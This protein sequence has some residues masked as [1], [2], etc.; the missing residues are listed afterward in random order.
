[1]LTD[2]PDAARQLPDAVAE[3]KKVG[4]PFVAKDLG[5]P[6]V[7]DSENA[8]P[9][10]NKFR[11]L[12]EEIRKSAQIQGDLDKAAA[13]VASATMPSERADAIKAATELLGQSEERLATLEAAASKPQVDFRRDWDLGPDLLFPEFAS[14]KAGIKLLSARAIVRAATDDALGAVQDLGRISAITRF[15]GQDP[16]IISLLV[17]IACE[18]IR[19]R[20]IERIT[21]LWSDSPSRLA[22]LQQAL[23]QE[24][25]PDFLY[26]MR[27]EVY[28]GIAVCRNL[29]KYGGADRFLKGVSSASMGNEEA[30]PKLDAKT[31][32]RDG[33]PE[34]E[35]SRAFMARHLQAWAGVWPDLTANRADPAKMGKRLDEMARKIEANKGASY[36]LSAVLY[37]VFTQAGLA[38]SR[39][40]A[41][42]DATASM[43]DVVR[44]QAQNGRLPK[45][46]AE[47]GAV[48]NDPFT[49][50][51]L[52]YKVE[53]TG[54]RI[55][56]VGADGID[57]HGV[58]R[59]EV[60]GSEAGSV[61][62]EVVA[63]PFKER[64]A[65]PRLQ[66]VRPT[67]P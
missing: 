9:A 61:F 62:D 22:A 15:S 41:V 45:T 49:G 58:A 38:V 18:A 11:R 32:R 50:K 34:D 56:S 17:Q 31:V 13:L 43:V 23:K 55:W 36:R 51:P 2:I 52:G 65:V 63:F 21:G 1:M 66:P 60:N 26:A 54:F 59:W 67:S 19:N 57:H 35:T 10:L 46:L 27:G 64:T 30:L 53:G 44:F 8:A 48:R 39:M 37:P 16:T 28:M 12:T 42:H 6:S 29:D 20:T 4:L 25:K 24:Q 5:V 40:K 3:A 33:L 14:M 7:P 47:A